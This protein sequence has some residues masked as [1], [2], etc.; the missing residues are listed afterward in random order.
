MPNEYSYGAF[1]HISDDV[2]QNATQAGTV[3]VYVGIAPVNLVRGYATAG[4]INTP[5]KLSNINEA[6]RKVGYTDDWANFSLCEAIDAHFN[7]PIGNMGPI[8][9]INVLD[10]AVHKAAATTKS[11]TFTNKIATIESDKIILDTFAMDTKVEG[12]DYRL[13]YDYGTKTLTIYDIGVTP[14]TTVTASYNEVDLAAITSATIIGGVTADGVSSGLASIKFLYQNFNAVT[15]IIAAPGWS[16]IPDVYTAMVAASQKINGHWEAFVIADIPIVYKTDIKETLAV[17]NKVATYEKAGLDTST[18]KVYASGSTTPATLTTDYTINY[19]D[20]TLTITMTD[21]GALA[22]ATSI[23]IEIQSSETVDT[24]TKAKQWK[25]DNSY[26]AERSKVYWPMGANGSKIYHLSTMAVVE[27]MRADFSHK[28][29]PMETPGNKPIPITRQYFGATS[30]NQGFDQ[31]EAKELTSNGI[32]TAIYWESNWRLWGDHT[33]A[34]TYGGSFNARAIFDTS[35]R[36]LMYITNSFQREWGTSIDKPMALSLQETILNREQ[37]KLETLKSDGALIGSPKVYFLESENQTTDLMN[38]D[39]RWD[40]S[41][42]PTP[43]LK[44]ATVY[45]TYTDEGF[46]AYFGGDQ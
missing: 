21:T 42:T 31:Q 4:I 29:I 12:V 24:I 44:S 7:N 9:V 41:V 39:F 33:A 27:M 37:E 6:K 34:Y 11:L 28:S 30:K 1:G 45:V 3:P 35:M 2:A 46:A 40:I 8:Y 15:N 26:S 16:K 32:S 23:D 43:P 18:L 10:P 5:V 22:T 36:M 17:T 19:T 25:I 14:L 38:G 20:G 13:S